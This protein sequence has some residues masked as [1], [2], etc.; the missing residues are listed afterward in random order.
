M[1]KTRR[2]LPQTANE[3]GY[4]LLEQVNQLCCTYFQYVCELLRIDLCEITPKIGKHANNKGSL[5]VKEDFIL[6]KGV[7]VD[8]SVL[9]PYFLPQELRIVFDQFDN[10]IDDLKVVF[11]LLCGSVVGLDLPSFLFASFLNDL[12]ELEVDSAPLDDGY[13][14]YLCG[15]LLDRPD[16]F[17]TAI[18][19]TSLISSSARVQRDPVPHYDLFDQ[20]VVGEQL[21]EETL[22]FGMLEIADVV[23]GKQI[24][25]GKVFF[26]LFKRKHFKEQ[27][28]C[29]LG[30]EGL[31]G[32][33]ADD[34]DVVD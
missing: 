5:M 18:V 34:K 26:E 15:T 31:V 8:E 21:N 6:A 19:K 14:E 32:R 16:E 9:V 11:L 7:F 22:K 12:Q 30:D 23:V 10:Y 1:S 13:E 17:Q 25:G 24:G 27:L 3:L 33:R 29:L 2:Q 28:C 20:I 4:Q